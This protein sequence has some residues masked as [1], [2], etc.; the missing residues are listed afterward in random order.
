MG[1]RIL[2]ILKKRDSNP[3]SCGEWNSPYAKNKSTGLFNSVSFIRIM[4]EKFIKKDTVH[5]VEVQDNNCIDRE[6][7]KFKPDVVIIEA[8]WC[9][10]EKFH[11][12]HKLHPHVSWVIRLHSETPFLANEGI[13]FE[14]LRKYADI[15]KVYL[16]AN[17]TRMVHELSRV[18]HTDVIYL[19]NYYAGGSL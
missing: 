11:I 9:V 13:A 5:M 16:A 2:F 3:Y 15:P 6:V 18:L 4:F 12:L 19:P 7:T 17:S 14:W 1:K 10:P 8:L